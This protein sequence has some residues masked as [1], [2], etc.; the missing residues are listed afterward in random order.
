MHG[1]NKWECVPYDSL[2]KQAINGLNNTLSSMITLNICD[3]R[4]FLPCKL[5]LYINCADLL[6]SLV[7]MFSPRVSNMSCPKTKEKIQDG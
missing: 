6:R 2:N 3:L 5:P 1:V 7:F 4:I